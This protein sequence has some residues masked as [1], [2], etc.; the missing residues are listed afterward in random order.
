VGLEVSRVEGVV[1]VAEFRLIPGT[2]P[3]PGSLQCLLWSDS[4]AGT[5]N[6]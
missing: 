3:C 6:R 1:R 4:I 5:R 2:S